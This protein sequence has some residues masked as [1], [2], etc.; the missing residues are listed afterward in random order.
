MS[1]YL[2]FAMFGIIFYYM[3]FNFSLNTVMTKIDLQL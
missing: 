1:K 2:F 3:C